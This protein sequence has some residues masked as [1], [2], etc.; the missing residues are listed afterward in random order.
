MPIFSHRFPAPIGSYG[1][2]RAEIREDF[3]QCCCYCLFHEILAAGE[4]NFELDHRAPKSKFAHLA[5]EYTNIYYSCHPCNHK[6]STYWPNSTLTA[7]GRVF[8][9]PVNDDFSTHFREESDGFWTPLTKKA[10]YTLAKINLNR[11][12]LVI[13]RGLLRK[14]AEKKGVS[15]IDWNNVSEAVFLNLVM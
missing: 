5:D 4:Q 10:E 13:L 15:Y 9:D 8:I 6:K 3:R 11:K 7:A 1:D 14:K 2:F 12:H